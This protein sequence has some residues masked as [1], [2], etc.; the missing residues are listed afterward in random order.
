MWAWPVVQS[1]V[2]EGLHKSGIKE[3]K[4]QTQDPTKLEIKETH[5]YGQLK[6]GG[7]LEGTLTGRY[8]DLFAGG[9]GITVMVSFPKDHQEWPSASRSR[10]SGPDRDGLRH[11]EKEQ[12]SQ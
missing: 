5:K 3:L 12:D 8:K 7:E 6:M 10:V 2:C 9:T 1:S 4:K 11:L